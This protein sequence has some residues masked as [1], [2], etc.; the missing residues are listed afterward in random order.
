[1]QDAGRR[2]VDLLLVRLALQPFAVTGRGRAAVQPG[3]HRRVLRVEAGEIGHQVL[4][5]R[6]VRQRVDADVTAEIG[7]RGR[8]GEA[9]DAVDVHR[10]RAADPLAAGAAE[11][12][13]RV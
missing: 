7:H 10:T 9:V 4:H 6:Q 13:G 5:H 8:A 11:G 12:Q 3:L 1:A 2:A